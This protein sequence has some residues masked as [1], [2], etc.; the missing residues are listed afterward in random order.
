VLVATTTSQPWTPLFAS[1][2][3]LVTDTGGVL[4]HT[5]VVAR[6]YGLPAVVGT[7][8]ATRRLRDGML[9]EV[10]GDRGLVRI[11]AEG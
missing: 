5:A 1:A 6:E 8:V 4:S 10:D 11:L 7:R 9:I 3:A 2:A